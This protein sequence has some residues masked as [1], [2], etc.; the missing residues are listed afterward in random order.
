MLV[1]TVPLVDQQTAMLNDWL[2]D[3]YLIIGM[4]GGE[5][6]GYKAP[7]VLAAHVFVVTPQILV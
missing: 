1:P 6:T 5:R 4:A 7:Y 3:R 2:G